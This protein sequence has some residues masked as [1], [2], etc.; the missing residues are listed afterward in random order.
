MNGLTLVLIALSIYALA[1]RLYGAWIAAKILTVDKNRITPAYK[2]QNNYDYVPT[3]KWVLFGHHFAAIAGAGPLV[4]PVLAAQF[5]YLPGLLWILIGAVIA[6]AVHDMVILFAS[7]R[8]NGSSIIDI[9]K[10]EVGKVAGV[11]TAI[12][13]VFILIL[14][15]AGLALVVVNALYHSVWGTFTVGAT[16][17]I[18]IYMGIHMKYI[19]KDDVLGATIIGVGLL[20]IT[21]LIGPYIEKTPLASYLIFST[22]QLTILLVIYGLAA[23]ILP[24]WL[25]LVPRDYL[26]TYLKLGVVIL[27]AIGVIIVN[28]QIRMPP[29]TNYING[30]GPII[31]G[32]LW[33]YVFITIAC[34][35]ISGFHALVSS[36]TTPKMIRNEKDI[37]PV[38]YGAMLAEGFVAIMALIA[39]TSLLPADYF[40][41]NLP[42]Q[43]FEKLALV[44]VELDHLSTMVGENIAGRPGGGV[45][46]A[47]GM[48]YIFSKIEWFKVLG[49]YLY[50]FVILFEALFILTTI[51]AGTRV[52]RYL[53]QEAC[54]LIYKPFGN[55]N[56]WPG[57]I[58][59]SILI[60]FAWGYLVYGG[61][62]S[63]I[64]PIF[65]ASNQL[66]AAIALAIATTVIIKK[67]KLRY[68]WVTFL[69][70]LFVTTT[71][72]YAT[73]LNIVNIYL[74]N[75]NWVLTSLAVSILVLAI[76]IITDSSIK[77]YQWVF[78][79]KLTTEEIEKSLFK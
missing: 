54:G 73:Y 41:I 44:P 35:A 74:P 66:L 15:M 77:W 55:K 72:L 12:A 5:G 64:W 34:G 20:I 8:Y 17:L 51:D 33:P 29:L 10:N 1:Y 79:H 67:G 38:A 46:L 61:S 48:T 37:L 9:A 58:T 62:I 65:G 13:V 63:T 78:N 40:A 53:L 25:L 4:G 70:F 22:K 52:G 59:C 11:A 19:R 26:S 16:I 28:P 39:A 43:L 71:T 75:K 47:V 24:V 23:A 56:W 3:N 18:A 50:H 36:G 14:A 21:V 60:S 57:I 32:P 7:I 27:L 6:G 30:G 2:L 31:P 42:P 45:T 69:P 49:A 76:A 68:V